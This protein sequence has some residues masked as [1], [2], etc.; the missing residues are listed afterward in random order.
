MRFAAPL[1]LLFLAACQAAGP[2]VEVDDEARA[3]TN[4]CLAELG[5]PTL[6]E[7]VTEDATVELTEAEQE[8]FRACVARLAAA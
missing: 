6:P 5:K 7:T 8:A 4:A 2:S 1:A 3:L